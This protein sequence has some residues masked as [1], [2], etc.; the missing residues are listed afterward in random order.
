M[1]MTAETPYP[2]LRPFKESEALYFFGQDA[3]LDDL[4]NRLYRERFVAIVGLSGCGKSSLLYA[5]LLADIRSKWIEGPRARWLIGSM[6]PGA[7]P[8]L[9]LV[10]AISAI[11][12]EVLE[13][14]HRLNEALPEPVRDIGKDLCAD[15]FGLA[16][17]GH[18]AG[19]HPQQRILI[20]VDQFEELFRYQRDAPNSRQ[21]DDAALFVQLLI[22]A[23]RDPRSSV[24]V[25]AT[26][27]SEFLGDCALF[28]GLA[29]LVNEGTFLL[30][31]IA[32]GQVE[33]AVTGPAEEVGA[34][35]DPKVVQE[36]LNEAEQQEDGLPLLQHALR[37]IWD[38][39]PPGEAAVSVND[40]HLFQHP[41]PEGVLLIKHHLDDHLDSIYES[42]TLERK[43]VAKLL[44]RLL[45]E[46]DSRG[47]LTRRPVPFADVVDAIGVERT[48]DIKEVVTAFRKEAQGRT[49][50]TPA[51]PW[52]PGES[53]AAEGTFIDV[54]HECLLRR[55]NRLKHW[56]E[57]EE[58]DAEQ[59]RRLADDAD[60]ADLRARQTGKTR[61]PLSGPSLERFSQWWQSAKLL[62]PAWA[63]RYEGKEDLILK[64]RLRS[65]EAAK[66][67]LEWSQR[68]A[69]RNRIWGAVWNGL[70]VAGIVAL[71][72]LWMWFRTREQKTQA[73]N[74][75]ARDQAAAETKY[76]E[77]RANQALADK[78]NE[79][80]LYNKLT[81]LYNSLTVANNK[82][83]VANSQ[84]QKTQDQ[85][86][87]KNDTL[88]I[89]LAELG[90]KTKELSQQLTTEQEDKRRIANAEKD[91]SVAR[92]GLLKANQELRNTI[93]TL[94]SKNKELAAAQETIKDQRRQLQQTFAPGSNPASQIPATHGASPCPE[95]LDV[96]NGAHLEDL[97]TRFLGNSRYAI[98]IALATN[99]RTYDGFSYIANPDDL[100]GVS[101]VCIPSKSS[102]QALEQSWQAYSR[103]VEAARLP[104][105]P[106]I[107]KKLVIIPPDQPVNVVAWVRTDQV[108][109]LKTASDDWIR[110]APGEI[111]VTVESHLQEFCRAFVREH[112][113]DES[114]LTR[115]LEQRL[116]LAPASNKTLFVRIRLDRPDSEV[117]FRPCADPAVDQAGCTVGPPSGATRSYQEWFYHQYYFSYG[118]SLISEFPWTSLGY[119]FD[120][121]AGPKTS[122]GFAWSG[123]SEFVIRKDAPIHILGVMNN[124]EYCAP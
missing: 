54:S 123:E 36:M 100:T 70:A 122:S 14:K 97:A 42:L 60:Q 117:I 101:R 66:E 38:R 96:P 43:R 90:D 69:R 86:N 61:E 91:A 107:A 46:R 27:R 39:R 59:F 85:L 12:R 13:Q 77:G 5:G 72:I 11:D 10:D 45:S 64:R 32:R 120:W 23:V 7:N 4:R 75:A 25:V 3:P 53:V 31:R 79:E 63:R 114:K 103:A 111:W 58:L 82:L 81:V 19:L 80:V 110:S 83:N 74:A 47:R 124:T 28:F 68:K 62:S 108:A 121:G 29:E 88:T 119:S 99:S 6:K 92:E 1:G 76:Q 16:R 30:P 35:I 102:A 48:A 22:E 33:E 78:H 56:I 18:E 94:N 41:L 49:F 37:R 15:G 112:H 9:N 44:F 73:D 93:D 87:A 84:L 17:Y 118:R 26:I 71:V 104:R 34:R 105:T 2:G 67:Y 98:S 50:L 20:V 115:R 116:G 65:F 40:F 52:V 57:L 51:E 55:W 8:L 106:E 95:P 21:K 113:P 89:T 24:S 109:R